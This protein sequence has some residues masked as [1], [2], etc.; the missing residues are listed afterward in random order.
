M[1]FRRRE[2]SVV[3]GALAALLALGAGSTIAG[4]LGRSPWDSPLDAWEYQ[5]G[6]RDFAG[7]DD[8][9]A[10]N[11]MEGGIA[12]LSSATFSGLVT[13]SGGYIATASST[14]RWRCA[15]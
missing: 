11:F 6:R 14:A 13:L 4:L 5:T 8:T 3:A 12:G 10:G 15:R 7:N 9:D 1:N 2:N